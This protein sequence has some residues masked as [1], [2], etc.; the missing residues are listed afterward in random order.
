MAARS[1]DMLR[2]LAGA[3]VAAPSSPA[4]LS[5]TQLPDAAMTQ[6]IMR[7]RIS[8]LNAK[9]GTQCRPDGPRTQRR[10]NMCV[11]TNPIKREATRRCPC[12]PFPWASQCQVLP[13][14]VGFPVPG[15]SRCQG[16]ASRYQGLP[17]A[18][19]FPVPGARGFPNACHLA[20]GYRVLPPALFSA[21][22]LSDQTPLLGCGSADTAP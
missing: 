18:R 4:A 9:V 3:Q 1:A 21:T 13:I 10:R 20:C 14:A 15:A 12:C 5:S 11:L 6:V 22:S 2:P 16:G 17:S 7:Y 19:G 8:H